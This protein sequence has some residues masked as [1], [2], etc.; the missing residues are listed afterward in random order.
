MGGWDV[1]VVDVEVPV[2]PLS[3]L[4]DPQLHLLVEAP[5]ATVEF[6]RC[7]GLESVLWHGVE[8]VEQCFL[9]EFPKMREFEGCWE[10]G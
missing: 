5:F 3:L 2:L 9:C 4:F 7:V 1:P 6:F 8:D 10:V